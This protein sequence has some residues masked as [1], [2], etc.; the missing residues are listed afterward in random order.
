MN[1]TKKIFLYLWAIFLICSVI[2]YLLHPDNFNA[3]HI[4]EFIA[5]FEG[6]LLLAYLVISLL[7][8]FTLLP[9]TPFVLAGVLLFPSNQII[10]LMISMV[11]ILFSATALYYLSE[12][13]EFD[14]YFEKVAPEKIRRLQNRINSPLGF[15]F[16]VVWSFF[17]LVPTDLICYLAGTVRM[18]F[19]KFILAVGL[20]EL[21]IC[22]FYIFILRN[23]GLFQAG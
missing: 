15:I 21:I 14:K 11:G 2:Y 4:G 3:K 22:L 9:S 13:L 18:I 6:H 23:I 20:G 19:F 7:R 5:R 10:V 16:V 8:G 12:W 1:K 17:P